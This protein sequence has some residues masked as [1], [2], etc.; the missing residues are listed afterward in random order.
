MTAAAR[1][2]SAFAVPVAMLLAACGPASEPVE[3]AMTPAVPT[4]T[5]V[6]AQPAP[7]PESPGVAAPTALSITDPSIARELM[8]VAGIRLGMTE[9]EAMAAL[10]AFE[11]A[12]TITR[13]TAFFGYTD[14]ASMFQTE[15]FIDYVSAQSGTSNRINVYFS[16][17]LGEPRVI[18]VG[19]SVSVVNGPTRTEFLETL[20]SRYGEP[21]GYDS[22]GPVWEESGRARCQRE[23]SEGEAVINVGR[24]GNFDMGPIQYSVEEG[25]TRRIGRYTAGLLPDEFTD[26]GGFLRYAIGSNG[27]LVVSFRAVLADVAGFVN[28][29]RE[30]SAWVASLTE[31]AVRRRQAQSQTPRL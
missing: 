15:D 13:N 20:L 28:V 17:P 5:P 18:K 12:A 25:L 31:E 4:A 2:F 23:F 29:E 24:V 27:D 11:P 10:N 9:A 19:R 16:G 6:S 7:A 3:Q 21:S 8:E 30:R 22:N 14:G 1:V 26:C